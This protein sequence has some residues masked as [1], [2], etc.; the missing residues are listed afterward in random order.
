VAAGYRTAVNTG[1]V[2]MRRFALLV[3]CGLACGCGSNV[4]PAGA[5]VTAAGGAAPDAEAVRAA[6]YSVLFVGNSHTAMHDLPG[7]VAGMIR[8]RHPAKT[9]VTHALWFAFLEDAAADP[10]CRTQVADRPWKHV[11]LQAQKIS[12]SGRFRYSQAEGIELAK[13]GKTRGA[14]VLFYAEWGLRGKAGD[15]ATQEAIYR[16]MATAA[17]VRVACVGRGWDAA[18][19]GRPD[20][21]LHADD[22]NHQ[23]HLG[24]F[25]TAAVLFGELTGDSPTVLADYPH[26]DTDAATRKLLTAAAAKA[27]GGRTDAK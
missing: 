22:G 26:P 17:G 20:L 25:L 9:V 10:G 6:D 1:D 23:S 2:P 27:V 15:G 18:L 11:V 21:P 19:A 12:T 8:H 4:P 5:P 16:E 3:L 13:A 14:D 24:A 7:V